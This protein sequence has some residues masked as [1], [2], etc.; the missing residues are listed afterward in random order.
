MPADNRQNL[1][2]QTSESPRSA[3][4][5]TRPQLG[6]FKRRWRLS[7]LRAGVIF[8]GL[9][10]F[11]AAAA[12]WLFFRATEIRGELTS[13]TNVVPQFK[14]ELLAHDDAAARATLTQIQ[15]HIQKARS[16]ATDPAWKAAGSVPGIGRNFSVVS[17]LVLSA[18]DVVQGAAQP[19]LSVYSTLDWKALKP[20]QGRLDLKAL[21]ASSP[22]IVAAANTVDLTYQRLSSIEGAGLLP[23]VAQPLTATKSSLDDLRRSLNIA[24]DTSALLPKM[25]GTD[26]IRNYLVLIQNNAEVRATGGL[27][28]ALAVLRLENGTMSLDAQSSGAALGK[29]SPAVDVDPAQTTIYSKRLGSYIS[30]V[31]LTPDFPTAAQAAKAMWE[32]RHGTRIDGV[33]ALDPVVLSH[34]LKASGPVAIPSLGTGQDQRL[35]H[36][37]TESNVV[38]ALLSDV[39]SGTESNELQDAYFASVSKEVFSLLASG[40]IPTDQL[41]DALATSVNEHRLLVWST[42]KEEQDV[43]ERTSAGGAVSGPTVG[44]ATFGVYF[45]DGTGAKMD[46]YV[47][48]TVRLES[49][50]TDSD[51]A[52]YKVKIT[53]ANSAP[54][55][56]ASVLPVAVTGDGRFGTP[57]GSIQTNVTVYGPALSHLDA[58]RQDNAKVSFGSHLHNDRPV[59]IVA[60]RLAPGQTSEIE[61]TF[62]KVVQHA[63]PA[64]VVTPTVQDIKEVLLPTVRPSC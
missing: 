1:T 44:G 50:C 34:I 9:L 18:D 23:E 28:G 27:P 45:N 39:Y 20:V 12:G 15:A 17:E 56:A 4:S 64:V 2:G 21:A 24:A 19:L 10:L 62:V 51:Y 55:D 36:M 49:V 52:E 58:A 6:S 13:L 60:A 11:T 31:N 46:Y 33:I 14:N 40:K 26:G 53:L 30:D 16:A 59:G 8:A 22:S 5:K 54:Q 35:P 41:L 61:M 48:K 42:Q 38:K 47:K 32:I 3:S 57:R 63:E 7:L 29:F 37:L 43:L 25:V